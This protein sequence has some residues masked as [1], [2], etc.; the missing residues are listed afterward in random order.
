M[1]RCCRNSKVS[2]PARYFFHR[3]PHSA[4]RKALQNEYIH[5]ASQLR[6]ARCHCL[7]LYYAEFAV[8]SLSISEIV[9]ASAIV[10]VERVYEVI[11][12]YY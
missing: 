8:I 9:L 3:Y 7:L 12:V 5:T 10:T 4:I 6:A 11:S 1:K 2:P